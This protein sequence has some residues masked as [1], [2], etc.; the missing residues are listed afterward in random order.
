M[1]QFER[2][3]SEIEQSQQALTTRLSA[4]AEQIPNAVRESTDQHWQKISDDVTG[5]AR[6]GMEHA[7]SGYERNLNQ[8]GAAI[9]SQASTL[10]AEIQRLEEFHRHLIWK[11]AA[12]VLGSIILLA[13]GGLYLSTHYRKVIAQNQLSAKL[14]QAYNRADV[15]FCG[16]KLCANVDTQG[17]AYKSGDKKYHLIKARKK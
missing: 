4:L 5:N 12:V 11:V 16:D 14:L 13:G 8:S 1:E 17:K 6:E 3:C 10:K 7:V 2:R 9:Q 15:T